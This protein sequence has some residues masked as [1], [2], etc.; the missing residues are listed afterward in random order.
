M[1]EKAARQRAE[2]HYYAALDLYADGQ[3]E[4]AVSEYQ[5]SLSADPTFT[6]AM[7]G[8]ARAYQDM[9]RFDDAVA[10]ARQITEVDPD[11]VLAHTILSILYQQKG[12]VPEA[13]AESAR[14]RILGWKQQ[15]K[16]SQPSAISRQNK[17]E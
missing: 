13:E 10:V 16:S 2:D 6:E 12:M 7:H 3:H 1:G 15:L 5:Q 8:L 14:A 9:E 17:A 4:A 11:D